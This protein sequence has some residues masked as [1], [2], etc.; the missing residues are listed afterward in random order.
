MTND[1]IATPKDETKWYSGISQAE[2]IVSL[3]GSIDSGNWKDATISGSGLAM[4]GMSLVFDP[5]A[6]LEILLSAGLGW[7][8]E[9]VAPLKQALDDLAGDP[10]VIKSYGET[11]KNVANRLKQVAQEH[12]ANVKAD[13]GGW[14]GPAAQSYR[15]EAAKQVD[16][17]NAAAMA[18]NTIGTSVVQAG[19]MVATVRIMVRD[20]I[21]TLV[22]ALITALLPPGRGTV[23]AVGMIAKAGQKISRLVNKLTQ[24]LAK[25]SDQ[26]NKLA[27]ALG[28]LV[29]RL[30]GKAPAGSHTPTRVT[31]VDKP[32]GDVPTV[33]NTGATTPSAAKPTT[34]DGGGTP[35]PRVG[36]GGGGG[37]D[38]T[39]PQN[40]S[41]PPP[42]TGKN[43]PS[44]RPEKKS[45]PR[46]EK[47]P[48][49]VRP[50]AP[51]VRPAPAPGPPAGA[52]GRWPVQNETPGGAVGQLTPG[53]CVSAC[54]EMLTNG[55]RS[56]QDLIDNIGAPSSVERLAGEL[57]PE[58]RGGYVDPEHLDTLAGRAPF[59]AELYDGGKIPHNV[60]VDGFDDA[61]NV[62]IR[63]P[64]DGGSTYTMT[65][66]DFKQYWNGRVV[67]K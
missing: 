4:D 62:R 10:P 24:S 27:G 2:E 34:P 52:G 41:G 8:M 66:E 35:P 43:P 33:R 15:G 28:P 23:K 19:A 7:V 22:T 29:R 12:A 55:A 64:W 9:H 36:N 32:S 57:G 59:V 65:R 44:V 5:M 31:A 21:A 47:N 48:P 50:A 11:W 18:A 60:V 61:G 42:R 26:L 63:D 38:G 58:W 54:G 45:P 25:L 6:A 37:G 39:P 13:I 14:T 67:F 20:T 49:P 53:S 16:A 3:C 46:A 17:M 40:S 51:P 56:Q 1:L 30:R